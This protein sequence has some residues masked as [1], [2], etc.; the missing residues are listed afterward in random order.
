M[1][2]RAL[3]DQVSGILIWFSDVEKQSTILESCKTS[4]GHC[5]AAV[6]ISPDN[7]DRTNKKMHA[8]WI[9]KIEELALSAECVAIISGLN[10]TREM[11]TH[12]A[13][14]T[15]LKSCVEVAGRLG[16]PLI[17]HVGNDGSSLDRVYE[18]LMETGWANQE[19][20]ESERNVILYDAL[21]VCSGDLQKVQMSVQKGYKFMIS[22]AGITDP[23]ADTQHA[24]QRCL[25]A[26]PL[27]H[28]LACTDSPWKTPQNIPDIYLRTLRNEPC[29]M[30]SVL[31]AIAT[32]V[33]IPLDVVCE[34]VYENSLQV[35]QIPHSEGN[36]A[37]SAIENQELGCDKDTSGALLAMKPVDVV[38]EGKVEVTRY[39]C[40][41]CRRLIV[42][43]DGVV[44]HSI[45]AAKTVFNIGQEGL[46][47]SSIFIPYPIL[48]SSNECD[49]ALLSEK[50]RGLD[51]I[52]IDKDNVH[53]KGCHAKLGRFS[54]GDAICGCGAVVPGPVLRVNTA[55]LDQFLHDS[56]ALDT[57]NLAAI[58]S[59]LEGQQRDDDELVG[60]KTKSKK[61]K[62]N[63]Q[64]SD[65]KG[66]FSSYRNKSFIPNA[67]RKK[68][69]QSS[70]DE[71]E[72]EEEEDDDEVMETTAEVS[73]VGVLDEED[74]EEEEG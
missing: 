55:K 29:N 71:E 64:K 12:F 35:F 70:S 17:L 62:K 41:K 33:E 16:L 7:I 32:S 31:D 52:I 13:Q 67:S 49:Q 43:N 19:S 42:T 45:V 22:G 6:G 5:Y 60:T 28:I 47:N 72:E 2:H 23:N 39:H 61:K 3:T 36:P 54:S 51:G 11:G 15:L 27:S 4:L 66:N 8:T 48:S 58:L 53:C 57:S 9:S 10:L 1:I 63:K 25:K 21:S 59:R 24:C 34:A 26:I 20:I 69:D 40:A 38:K 65:N 14:E 56:D 50:F 73:Q 44:T 37:S 30:S 74:E 68:K 18:I 46:C